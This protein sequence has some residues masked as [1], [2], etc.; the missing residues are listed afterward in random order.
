MDQECFCGCCGREIAAP[1]AN[2]SQDWCEPCQ[3]HLGP[4][5]LAPWD[6]TYFAQHDGARCPY[7]E[8]APRVTEI[9]GFVIVGPPRTKKTHSRIVTI[10]TKGSHRCRLCGKMPGF[11]KLLP[12]EAYEE[13][14]KAALSQCYG[15]KAELV[16]RGVVL[17]L[18]ASVSIEA[19]IYRR[20][21]SGDA[22]G[23][24]QAIGDMLQAAGIIKDDKQIEDWDGSRRLKDAARPRVEIYI[25]VIEDIPVQEELPLGK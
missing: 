14:E 13:W 15:I 9:P 20:Q 24:Y 11:P 10:P 1:I 7:E 3:H 17:P 5:N 25:S 16:R 22:A 8:E 6:R 18:V 4:S 19:L 12:S 2:Y 21:A 23:F